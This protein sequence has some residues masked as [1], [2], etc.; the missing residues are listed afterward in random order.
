MTVMPPMA[1]YRGPIIDAHVHLFPW[2]MLQAVIAFFEK[3]NFTMPHRKP[4]EELVADLA[5]AGVSAYTLLNYV[6]QPGQAQALNDWTVGFAA[7]HPEAIPFGTVHAADP[8]PLATIAPF[9]DR[10]AGLKV[11]PLVSEFGVDD[12]R[13]EPVLARLEEADKILVTHSGTAPYANEFVGLDRLVA[14]MRRHPRLR[15]VLAHMGAFEMDRAFALLDEFPNL[16]LDT[17]VIFVW[18]EMFPQCEVPPAEVWSR[19]EDRILF[20]SDFPLIAYPY[21][22]AQESIVRLPLSAA[23]REKIY[24]RNAARLFG[25]ADL[26]QTREAAC[27]K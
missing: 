25:R 7:D 24:Y 20:G 21:A 5:A 27:S 11:Q 1:V 4:A 13:I 2:R 26:S 9:L 15:V 14:V 19:Y 18:A 6:R 16:Y 12:P 3:Y 10:L 8:N 22:K 17:A 23:G